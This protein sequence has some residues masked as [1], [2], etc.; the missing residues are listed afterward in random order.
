ML[1]IFNKIINNS[2]NNQQ[3]MIVDQNY[4][5]SDFFIDVKRNLE[6]LKSK[7]KEKETIFF[8]ADYSK[9]FISMI[10]A[11]YENKNIITFANPSSKKEEIMHII[12][13]S[14]S[15]LIFL[16]ASIDLNINQKF[17]RYLN[18]NYCVLKKR[19]KCIRPGDI[20][21]I[22]TSGTTKKPKGAI[23]TLKSISSNV[24]AIAKNFNLNSNSSTII[25]SPPAYAM[26]ISQVLTFMSVFG[27]F[28]LYNHGLKFPNEIID[29][30][31]KFKL[32]HL[33][34]SLSAFRILLKYNVHKKN[35]NFV[36]VVSFGGMQVIQKDIDLYIKIFPKSSLINFY[37]C[38]E[39][40]P[41]ISHFKINKNKKY[42]ICPV[43][44]LLKGVKAKIKKFEKKTF[45]GNI[46]ISG[47][48]LMRR[49][50]KISLKSFKKNFYDTG[51]LG[52][53]DK[54]RNLV[55]IGRNDFSFRVGHEK[56]CPEEVESL[57]KKKL[58]YDELI[59][60]K[61]EHKILNFIPVL[62]I[63]KKINFSSLQ[64]YLDK[65]IANYKIPKQLYFIDK[66]PLTN[67]G[68][69]DRNQAQ[70]ILCKLE[71]KKNY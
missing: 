37:G 16:E 62:L 24:D 50:N 60:C 54:Q 36:K 15:S 64:S 35:F 5:Y 59:I 34:L 47:S 2:K 33:N 43:G 52:Y 39:N 12:N 67:Y 48:S 70:K 25:F 32:N 57:I 27:K 44:K 41:R 61:K 18:F 40:S 17:N 58:N 7:V 19:N 28:I 46:I 68:K 63:N 30:I 23:L 11:A 55:I 21:I 9:N 51:D 4:K 22:Y 53:F 29:L 13:D 66:I 31:I 1:D 8:C 71:L 10:F 65:N 42:E 14:S 20:F 49:Y 3:L 45:Y 6:F 56:L 26:G 38:T 69:I